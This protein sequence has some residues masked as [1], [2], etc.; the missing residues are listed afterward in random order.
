M[1]VSASPATPRRSRRRRSCVSSSRT[2]SNSMPRSPSLLAPETV[3]VLALGRLSARHVI[4]VRELLLHT[5]G[6]Y[7]YGTD[8]D[9][10]AAVNADPTK[11]WTRLEQ[12]RFA[13]E[14]GRPVG[15]PGALYAYSDTG[16]ALLGEILE[17][18]TGGSLRRRLPDACS[19]SLAC[20]STPPMSSCSSRRR[21]A[22]RLGRTSTSA[23]STA[24]MPTRPSTGTAP[25]GSSRPS[26]TSPR[27]TA[28][29][30]AAT[31]SASR[32]RST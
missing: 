8:P 13:V 25:P 17:R 31:C 23:S 21:R 26:T 9:Y 27:S 30:C 16:Y 32:K 15:E 6:I 22:P 28:R 10:Q 24:S 5:S 14:H 12:V 7:N 18:V 20:T 19:T 3:E 2:G 1:L 4:T 29:C 11:H